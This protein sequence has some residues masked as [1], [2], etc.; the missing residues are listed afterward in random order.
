MAKCRK[1]VELGVWQNSPE[2]AR[3]EESR[4]EVMLPERRRGTSNANSRTTILKI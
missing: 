3:T 2:L 4:E 1:L